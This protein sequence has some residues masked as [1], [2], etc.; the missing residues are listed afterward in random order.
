MATPGPASLDTRRRPANR[1]RERDRA[2]S[3]GITTAPAGT[4]IL[5]GF[6]VARLGSFSIAATT[7]TSAAAANTT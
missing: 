5:D 6:P 4:S 3:V 2:M 7:S 1:A